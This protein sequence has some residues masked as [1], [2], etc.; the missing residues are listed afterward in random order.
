MRRTRIVLWGLGTVL[1]I[2]IIAAISIPNLLKARIPANSRVMRSV[3]LISPEGTQFN[4]LSAKLISAEKKVIFNGNLSLIV[5][6]VRK[7]ADDIRKLVESQKGEIQ[8]MEVSGSRGNSMYATIRIRVPATSL[9]TNL[10]A[11]KKLALWTERESITSKDVT[12]EFYDN[13]AHLHNLRA[14]EEQYLKIMQQAHTVKDTLEVSEKL[15]DVRDRVERLQT[16]IQLMTHDIEMSVVDIR[17]TEESEARVFGIDWRPLV[18]AKIA[19]RELL[20]GIVEWIDLIVA[21]IIKLPLILLWL[22][23]LVVFGTAAWRIGR[24][25]WN[26]LRKTATPTP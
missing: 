12:R 20:T 11:I 25:I 6:D 14:E 18:N 2:A 19:S 1:A 17:L 15:S 5:A 16:Q 23:T 3:S 22:L 13:E 10:E 4:D 21:F 8:E 26:R 9:S 24:R 7:T